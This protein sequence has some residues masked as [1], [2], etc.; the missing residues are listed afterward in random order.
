MPSSIK[1]KRTRRA[2]PS[3]KMK[4]KRRLPKHKRLR[5]LQRMKSKRKTL[6]FRKMILLTRKLMNLKWQINKLTTSTSRKIRML[7]VESLEKIRRKALAT[8]MNKYNKMTNQRNQQ[9][10]NLGKKR[11]SS[12]DQLFLRKIKTKLA[13]EMISLLDSMT[14]M[15]KAKKRKS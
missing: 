5:M 9:V 6:P 14:W 7:V 13:T 4:L 15:T 2:K 11:S 10:R 1:T 12:Q 8:R 3:K